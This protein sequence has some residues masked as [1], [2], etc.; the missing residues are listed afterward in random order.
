MTGVR[1]AAAAAID[2]PGTP[3]ALWAS[4]DGLALLPHT[5][6][7]TGPVVVVAAHPDDEV[8]GF[9][10]TMAALAAAGTEVHLLSVTDGEGS[11]PRSA[12]V[13][14]ARL[15][16]VRA[17]ELRTALSDLGL[18]ALEP[19]RLRVPDTQVHRHEARVG[20]AVAGLLREVGGAHCVA[21][22]TGDLHSDHEAAGRAAAAACRE[23]DTPLWLYPVWMWHWAKPADPRV[24][25]PEAARLPVPDEAAARKRRAVGRF[26]SQTTPLGDGEENAAILPPEELAHHTRSFEVVFR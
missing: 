16:E 6:P 12:R 9:G 10:G 7:P 1:Q 17:A 21:P 5:D 13:T 23:A 14:A 20:D 11:H 26:T 19:R 4:W 3:E 2:A 15:A 22:W 25:W 8:L 18:P 24:P